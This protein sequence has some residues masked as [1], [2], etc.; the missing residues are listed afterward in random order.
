MCAFW[1]WIAAYLRTDAGAQERVHEKWQ[2][3]CS[4]Q[5]NGL[6]RPSLLAAHHSHQENTKKMIEGPNSIKWQ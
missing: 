2:P 5:T 4:L 3:I 6:R 1:T